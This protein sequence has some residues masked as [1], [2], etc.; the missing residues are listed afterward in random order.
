MR[1][2]ATA[3]QSR[4]RG[5]RYRAR[6]SIR[7]TWK[8]FTRRRAATTELAMEIET[9]R[10][11]DVLVVDMSGRLDSHSAGE[12]GD[13]MV[14]IAQGEDKR[15]L[16]NLDK[17]AYMSSA[18]MRVIIRAAKLLQTHRGELKIC[19]ARGV[20]K[21]ALETAGFHSLI[22]IYDSEKEAFSAFAA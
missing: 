8:R 1:G 15:V 10:V 11:Y 13:R 9:R 2:L 21:D 7:A 5:K 19:N 3:C 16:L 20:V 14:N 17:L 12:A 22:K 6:R 4:I 18:G